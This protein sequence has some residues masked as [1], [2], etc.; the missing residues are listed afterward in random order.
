M[1]QIKNVKQNFA[2]DSKLKVAYTAINK[3][4]RY[5][6]LASDTP[7]TQISPLKEN[8]NNNKT[9][10]YKYTHFISIPL[11]ISSDTTNNEQ[12][13]ISNW[14]QKSQIEENESKKEDIKIIKLKK[15]HVTLLLLRLYTPNQIIKA[16]KILKEIKL[17]LSIVQ[18]KLPLYVKLDGIGTF[19]GDSYRNAKTQYLYAYDSNNTTNQQNKCILSIL[20]MYLAILYY[21]NNLQTKEEIISQKIFSD[22]HDELLNDIDSKDLV[23]LLYKQD[24]NA[25]LH[26]T[27][28][29]CHK[30]FQVFQTLQKFSNIKV[31][32]LPVFEIC[33]CKVS[34]TADDDEEYLIESSVLQQD[35]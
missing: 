21:K 28:A 3:D 32:K 30:V 29:K 27:L 10:K 12:Q 14:I 24:F 34:N 2:K 17:L 9:R 31:S 23:K 11:K 19:G 16:N 15:M 26:C 20:S 6:C 25:T 13:N 4:K 22:I 35:N 18:Y 5:I 1:E 8:S 7:P 33:L